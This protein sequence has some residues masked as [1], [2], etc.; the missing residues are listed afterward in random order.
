MDLWQKTTGQNGPLAKNNRAKWTSG[1]KQPGES[2]ASGTQL[3]RIMVK[4]T[5]LFCL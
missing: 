2:G 1:K 3:A 4:S 5:A